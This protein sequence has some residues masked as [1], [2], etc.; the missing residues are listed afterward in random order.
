M[1]TGLTP[2]ALQ[3][4]HVHPPQHPQVLVERIPDC[5]KRTDSRRQSLVRVALIA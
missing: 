1:N 5:P 3:Q 4:R 2:R